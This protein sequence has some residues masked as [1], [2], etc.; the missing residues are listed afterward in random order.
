[1]TQD[2][3]HKLDLDTAVRATREDV[4]TEE[5][6]RESAGR[7]WQ[8]MQAAPDVTREVEQIRGCDDVRALLPRF[9][10]GALT[11]STQMLMEAH[12]REC[13]AC[14]RQAHHQAAEESVK[15]AAPVPPRRFGFRLP[16]FAMT[17][18]AVAVIA[19]A[20]FVVNN[21]YFAV[22]AGARATVQSADGPV[23]LATGGGE[24]LIGVGEPINDGDAVRT[25]AGAHAF[26]RLSDGSLVEMNERSDFAASARGRNMTV[27][28]DQGA[29]I[30]EAAKRKSGHLYVKTPD[31]RVAVTGT[32]FSVNAGVKG[33]RVSVIEGAV[34]VSAVNGDSTLHAGDQA[35]TGDNMG[36]VPVRTDIAW[37]RDREKHLELLAQFAQLQNKLQQV[38]LPSPR[39]TSHLAERVPSDTVFY[40]SIPNIGQALSEAN[41]IFQNQLAQSAVLREWWTR[42]NAHDAQKMNEAVEN[43]RQLSEYLGDEVVVAGFNGRDNRSDFA[44][45]AEVRR[46]GLKEALAG[47]VPESERRS[48]L[49]VDQAA[50]AGLTE[51]NT[52]G[53]TI[54]LVRDDVFVFSSELSAIDKVV[55]QLDAGPSNFLQSEFGARVSEAYNRGAGFLIAANLQA[56]I[57]ND[58]RRAHGR[59]QQSLDNS[60]VSDMRYLIAEH[61]EVNGAPDNRLVLDF[62]KERRGVASWLAAPAPMGSLEF[63][64]RNAGMAFSFIA[65]DPQLIFDDM[66]AITNA[67]RSAHNDLAETETRL[68]LRIRDD[69][70]A[71]FGGDAVV[72]LDGPVLPTPAWKLV[73]EVRDPAGLQAS[74]EKVIA[75]ANDEARQ[76]GRRGLVLQ[77][78]DVQ[79]QRFYSVQSLDEA[80]VSTHYTF[81][82]GYMIVAQSRAFVMDSLHVHASGDSLARS[83]E[84][85]KLLPNDGKQNYSAILYQNLAPVLQPLVSTLN[86]EKAALVQQLAGDSRPSVICATG[87]ASSIEASSNSRL[88]GFDWLALASLLDQ[89]TP[90]R[91][92][93]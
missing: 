67:H 6:L 78:E 87:D 76:H 16:A 42:G 18:A 45:V 38:Q 65:K 59:A 9:A 53:H 10:A 68:R 75:A 47:L 20:A 11:A 49:I 51:A 81:A 83:A 88:F 62:T 44:L 48:L 30:V 25:G 21:M 35:V 1:M 50:L 15:W 74:L 40:A 69:L 32:V 26:L 28:L 43:L 54:A 64:S 90:H 52:G 66:L 61:R 73:V 37:S 58:N 29:V 27:A 14:S 57:H 77:Q 4:P 31:C 19:L 17:A 24:R 41:T 34:Q 71:H 70:A 89:G 79:G 86:A 60:G 91:P 33:S 7:V 8:K 13:V 55:A 92:R 3:N 46:N 80:A 63:V 56:M 2:R 36:G 85:K 93:T 23:Y 22:P 72:A 82:D 39:F 12:L 5:Q 84:F